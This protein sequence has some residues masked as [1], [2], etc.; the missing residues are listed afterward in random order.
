M[1]VQIIDDNSQPALLPQLGQQLDQA[2]FFEMM[3]EQGGR[4]DVEGLLPEFV[5]EDILLHVSDLSLTVCVTTGV[6]HNKRIGINTD[7]CNWQF[8]AESPLC[9]KHEHIATAAP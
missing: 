5:G 6:I 1:A 2:L 4:D 7:Q 8:F 3:T 9:H